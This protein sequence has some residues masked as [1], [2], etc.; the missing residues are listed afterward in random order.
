MQSI[1]VKAD[2]I[3]NQ[4]SKRF[5]R[6][7]ILLTVPLIERNSLQGRMAGWRGPDGICCSNLR[8]MRVNN[9]FLSSLSFYSNIYL[10]QQDST[11]A[12]NTG[13]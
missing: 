8:H 11:Y 13:I 3:F 1:R 6:N 12:V 4:D 5:L 2:I 9:I 10:V 7:I